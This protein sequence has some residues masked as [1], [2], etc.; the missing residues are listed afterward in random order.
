MLIHLVS[1]AMLGIF[2]G[3]AFYKSW[4]KKLLYLLLGLSVAIILHILF[5]FFIMMNDI[6][7]DISFFWVACL[8]T[9]I[10]V[11]VLLL[12]F[13]KVKTVTRR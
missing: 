9:W 1:S 5:N 8:G 4:I 11:I 13:E 12:F 7:H 2:I 3:L 10:L 6:T